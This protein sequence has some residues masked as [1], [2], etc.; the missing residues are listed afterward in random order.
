MPWSSGQLQS[1]DSYQYFSCTGGILL[2]LNILNNALDWSF[3]RQDGSYSLN[4]ETSPPS[5]ISRPVQTDEIR[6]KSHASGQSAVITITVQTDSEVPSGRPLVASSTPNYLTI[7][8][9]TGRVSADFSGHIHAKGVDLPAAVP[10]SPQDDNRVRWLLNG[11]NVGEI[12][13]DAEIGPFPPKERTIVIRS[14]PD[15]PADDASIHIVSIPS[16]ISYINL[17]AGIVQKLLL[18]DLGQSDWMLKGSNVAFGFTTLTPLGAPFAAKVINHD[19]GVIPSYINAILDGYS[20]A[21]PWVDSGIMATSATQMRIASQTTGGG[22]F[23]AGVGLY[24]EARI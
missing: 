11:L 9:V 3:R 24:W 13:T 12:Y 7:D 22:A 14:G 2:S 16:G 5:S 10:G 8:P 17:S 15:S 23:P 1:T 21:A 19:L 20:G 18:D 4:D 6:F